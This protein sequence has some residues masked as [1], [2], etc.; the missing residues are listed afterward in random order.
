MECRV[1]VEAAH[2]NNVVALHDYGGREND[3]PSDG[4]GVE[5]KTLPERHGMLLDG[6]ILGIVSDAGDFITQGAAARLNVKGA[7]LFVFVGSH[8]DAFDNGLGEFRTKE[9]ATFKS[10]CHIL[11]L[12]GRV[13]HLTR[14]TVSLFVLHR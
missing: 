11:N 6:G 5:L 4:L 2:K 10:L 9:M 13:S 14:T 8:G 1:R 3:A 7:S 12:R